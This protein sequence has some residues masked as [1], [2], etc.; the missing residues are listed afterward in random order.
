VDDDVRNIF[1]LTSALEQKGALV[2]VGR[3]G[4]EALD[5]LDAVDD[6]DLVLMD[7]MMPEMD[8]LEATRRSA[9]TRWRKL[10]I[11]A[12]TA[13][14]MK[15]DQER[16]CRPAPTI[17]WPSRST[18]RLF[19]LMRVWMPNAERSCHAAQRHRHRAEDADGGHLPQV[20][21]RFPRLPALRKAPRAAMR[22]FECD[23]ISAL[24]ARICTTRPRSCQLLQY[25]T[26]PVSEMFRDPSYFAGCASEVV[27]LLRTYP[28]LK[29]WIAGCSTGE[30]VY[31]MA[32]LLR[33][34]G[35]LERTIIYATDIN[36]QSLEKARK[37]VFP[38]EHARVHRQ[39]PGRRHAPFPSTTRP[40]TAA[41]ST[42]RCART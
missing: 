9:P 25:L 36:P 21:L 33:E 28:S 42:S 27:P 37:G 29:I 13:K 23:S 26:I 24:Q 3:N 4:H 22:E 6:I 41:R 19:S 12:V 5:K 18:C 30:E 14:A 35:L 38:L 15:D 7:V 20:Q 32:I 10:P 40:P 8:G 2:E 16:A 31:S 39:L 34:E 17:T 11:I 1:A